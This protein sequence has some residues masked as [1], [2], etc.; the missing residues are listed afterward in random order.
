MGKSSP[1]TPAAP[2]PAKTAAAQTASNKELALWNSALNN[3]NQ[4]TPYGNMTWT[5][6][7]SAPTGGTNAGVNNG[8][9][10]NSS[11]V[12]NGSQYVGPDGRIYGQ[13]DALTGYLKN[14]P[15]DREFQNRIAPGTVYADA[16]LAGYGFKP[17]G[18]TTS[19][20]SSG[21]S[22][23]GSSSGFNAN[24]TPQWTSRIDL[25]PDQQAI[26]D[27]EERRQISMGLLGEDQIGRIRDSVST[28]Y[29]YGGIGN[30]FSAEDIATQQRNAES[31]Y[32]DRLNPQFQR[33]EEAL[34][35]RLINQGIGQGSQAYQREMDTFNQMRN[36][37]RSQAVLAGQQYGSTAQQQALQRR[38]QGIQEYDAQRNAP[39]N[40]YIGLTSGTQVTNPQFSSQSYQGAAPVDYAGLVNQNYQNQVAQYNAK[41]AGSNN[42]MSS[43]FGLGGSVAGGFAGSPAGSA[44]LASSDKRL[45]HSIEYYDEKEGHK[46]YKFRYNAN[47]DKEFIG[48]MAQEVI[49]K[50][51]LAV[52]MSEDGYYMVDYGR[53][54]FEMEE[55]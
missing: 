29:S 2:D 30:E 51:P 18:G 21:S 20:T 27:S 1:K 42:I 33:D 6:G 44:W 38:N 19:S 45:K 7:N 16:D 40:E 8:S 36:D 26:L 9:S 4:Y 35:T 15:N 5:L 28:P 11:Q 53:L 22:S 55:V 34:R 14:N 10:S 17:L 31:A 25:S 41:Q 13:S 3:V 37:A 50:D 24:G 23:S 52:E 12:G 54:G 46:R 47:P 48:V 43:L 39:L 49:E 32:M